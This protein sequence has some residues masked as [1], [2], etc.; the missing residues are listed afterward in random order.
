M[1]PATLEKIQ[2]FTAQVLRPAFLDIKDSLEDP[3]RTVTLVSNTETGI[4]AVDAMLQQ[5]HLDKPYLSQLFTQSSVLQDRSI[6]TQSWIGESLCVEIFIESLE[7]ALSRVEQY[8]LSIEFSTSPITFATEQIRI[9][10]VIG[11]SKP[12]EEMLQCRSQLFEAD[13][14]PLSI[15]EIDASDISSRF[16]KSYRDFETQVLEQV[17]NLEADLKP[18]A[19]EPDPALSLSKATSAQPTP[20]PEELS[21]SNTPLPKPDQ[22]SA[23]RAESLQQDISLTPQQQ[24]FN[25]QQKARD[26]SK[27]LSPSPHTSLPCNLNADLDQ[28]ACIVPIQDKYNRTIDLCLEYSPAIAESEL[29]EYL[30]RLG[31][32]HSL[33]RLARVRLPIEEQ[34]QTWIK[35]AG[36]P[37]LGAIAPHLQQHITDH[38]RQLYQRLTDLT[39]SRLNHLAS[40][41]QT[42]L[43]HFSTEQQQQK[44]F[45]DTL[46]Q[47]PVLGYLDHRLLSSD[48][49]L[50]SIAPFTAPNQPL[51][52]EAKHLDRKDKSLQL[53]HIAACQ[54]EKY[55]TYRERY[56][57]LPALQLAMQYTI[58]QKLYPG[59]P[60]SVGLAAKVV[61]PRLELLWGSP[62]ESAQSDDPLAQ[63]WCIQ[64]MLKFHPPQ[65]IVIA[66]T[67]ETRK[68]TAIALEDGRMAQ[69]G[70]REYLARSLQIMVENPDEYTSDLGK[71]I[72]EALEQGRVKYTHLHQTQDLETGEPRD[73]V[74]LQFLL[75]EIN[76][77]R[78]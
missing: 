72:A 71:L 77:S 47:N 41:L 5:M 58:T 70:T 59:R 53:T 76:P 34:L 63:I 16:L 11:Y 33:Q 35:Q 62:H 39:N 48:D 12:G 78:R 25:L 54:S 29:T 15:E 36:Q 30:Q 64:P 46:E 74:Q 28:T 7:S 8:C 44:A 21:E 67:S 50:Q 61:H 24:L 60:F 31:H 23:A 20:Y 52:L 10:S 37:S 45:L 49:R 14:Q 43:D 18:I 1:N 73:I 38:S 42:E 40:E 19:S 4:E 55:R 69:E 6:L 51:D 32:Y 22:G 57:S 66:I 27:Q 68:L 56:P 26:L 9:A 17:V 65:W 2:A 75:R 3:E 13:F